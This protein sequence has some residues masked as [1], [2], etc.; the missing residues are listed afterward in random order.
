MYQNDHYQ[1]LRTLLIDIATVITLVYLFLPC[2]D[3]CSELSGFFWG[4]LTFV[5]LDI[6]ANSLV[7]YATFRAHPKIIGV[8]LVYRCIGI[9]LCVVVLVYTV[10]E[11][12]WTLQL[13][14]YSSVSIL[15]S[16]FSIWIGKTL[17]KDMELSPDSYRRG[18]AV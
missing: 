3:Y 7:I 10:V 6:I 12:S 8:W 18:F 11:G 16:I 1:N 14:F 4:I 13:V 15:L 2:G 17:K 5:L 9:A